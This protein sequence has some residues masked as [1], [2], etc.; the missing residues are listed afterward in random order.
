MDRIVENFPIF[1]HV[2]LVGSLLAVI[3]G[4]FVANFVLPA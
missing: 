1:W 2:W 3:A 4:G